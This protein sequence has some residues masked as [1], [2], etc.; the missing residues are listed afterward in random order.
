MK[1]RINHCRSGIALIIVMVMVLVFAGLAAVLASMMSV[2]TRLARNSSWNN[3]L[4]VLGLSGIELAKAVLSQPNQGQPYDG[5]NQIWAGGNCETND[6]LA[7]ITLENNQL[8]HGTFSV[9][10]TDAD[11]KFNINLAAVAPEMLNQGLI[12]MGVDAAEAPHIVNAVADWTDRDDDPRVGSTETESSYYMSLAPPYT[13]KN[14]PIDDLTELMMIKGITPNMYFGGGGPVDGGIVKQ[15]FQR[16][17]R[18]SRKFSEEEPTYAL[19]FVDLFTAIS[20]RLININTA[21]ANVMQLIPDV[22]GTLAQAI[23]ST[24]AG[25]DG[26]DGTCDDMPF[27]SIGEL[28]NVPGMPRE[29]AQLFGRYFSTRSTTFEVEVEAKIDAVTR[30]YHAVLRRN[31]PNQVVL[32]YMYWR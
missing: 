24:R 15:N 17:L 26:A 30:T 21:S 22:D 13:A 14:G 2:E 20:G 27:R 12:L 3:E 7:D 8:G 19:G 18:N 31:A 9:K 23:I 6:A 11:R 5:L 16:A 4:Y 29:L 10:I 32:L 28:A 25:P 1:I